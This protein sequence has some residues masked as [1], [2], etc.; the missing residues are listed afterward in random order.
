MSV[1]FEY[2]G[3]PVRAVSIDGEPGFV[4]IPAHPSYL[5]HPDG[6]VYSLRTSRI[7]AEQIGS[8][9]IWRRV[10]VDG[11][12]VRVRDLV[13]LLFGPSLEYRERVHGDYETDHMDEAS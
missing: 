13:W 7:L 1:L 3:Q 12:Q 2:E 9:S 5:V 6:R 8:K 10:S 4:P 11:V